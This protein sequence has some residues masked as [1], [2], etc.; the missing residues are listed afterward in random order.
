MESES[1]AKGS[2]NLSELKLR[3]VFQSTAAFLTSLLYMTVG[4]TLTSKV[5]Q[6]ITPTSPV[7]P[8]YQINPPGFDALYPPPPPSYQQSQRD[9]R[10][11]QREQQAQVQVQTDSIIPDR[12]E[13][14]S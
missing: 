10:R 12:A 11:S 2:N 4:V 9:Q 3:F 6:Q 8:V 7:T 13:V 5:N 1:C 14:P